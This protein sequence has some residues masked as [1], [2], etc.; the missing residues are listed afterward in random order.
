MRDVASTSGETTIVIGAGQAGFSFCAR[1]R[2]LGYLGDIILIGDEHHAP[3]QR[4]PLSK[5]YLLGDMS[6]DRMLLRPPEFYPDQRIDLRTDTQVTA[7]TPDSKTVTLSDG[8]RLSYDNLILATG[9]TPRELPRSL[10]GGLDR[11]YY[12]RSIADADAIEPEFVSGRRGLIVGGGY[13][14]LEAAAVAA[15][16][17][18]KTV[19]IEAADRILQRV[20][21]SQTSDYFKNLHRSHGVDIRE[22]IG[23]EALHGKDGHV[24]SA[25][26]SDG[27]SLEIDFVIAGIGILPNVEL[28][29]AAGVECE[30][31][32]RVDATCT[33]S[34]SA[35]MAIGDCACFPSN[36]ARLRLESVGNAIDQGQLAAANVMGSKE[37]YKAKPWFWSD[38]YD[39]KLQIAGLSTNFDRIIVRGGK[40]ASRSH[41]YFAGDD[42]LA[43]DA[44]NDPRAYMVAK[45]LIEAGKSPPAEAVSDI[46][47]DLKDLLKT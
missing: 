47:L 11:I 46:N 28:A 12:M 20:A 40:A 30:N 34:D 45:R 41:W 35:I 2:E 1:L 29:E 15:K 21:C 6:L 39:V 26:L 33:T 24:S 38:Q 27:T 31:G 4:P 5:A 36:G 3:Y 37:P 7:I 14:G 10:S 23:L 43:V 22:G 16:R 42:L 8:T 25:T 32:I 18:V 13:I 44:M 9:S 17:G 19:L